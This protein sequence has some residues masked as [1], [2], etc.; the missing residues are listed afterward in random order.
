MLLFL[1]LNCKSWKKYFGRWW[2]IQPNCLSHS[3][4]CSVK[5][6]R[7][8][9][10]PKT[11]WLTSILAVMSNYYSSSVAFEFHSS[12]Y[13][14]IFLSFP[15]L[16]MIQHC[17]RQWT[18]SL[19]VLV[20]REEIKIKHFW[21]FQ[22]SD[23]GDHIITKHQALPIGVSRQFHTR[24]FLHPQTCA[25]AFEACQCSSRGRAAVLQNSKQKRRREKKKDDSCP[26]AALTKTYYESGV[27]KWLPLCNCY[28]QQNK[29]CSHALNVSVIMT[30]C[31]GILFS[32]HCTVSII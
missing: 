1:H 25:E 23:S 6:Y 5:A 19:L 2:H 20:L 14:Y 21:V 11:S 16:T 24:S 17:V 3:L 31:L 28:F 13:L 32:Y 15:R 9:Y 7:H 18:V 12:Y 22:S 27:S 4:S 8:I 30:K 10:D 29:M 26:G